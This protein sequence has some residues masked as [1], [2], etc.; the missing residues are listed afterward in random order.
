MSRR[1]S[2]VSGPEIAARML[3]RVPLDTATNGTIDALQSLCVE[4]KGAAKVLF[5]LERPRDFL[6]VLEAEGYNVQADRA[7]ISRVEEL[8][9]RNSVRVID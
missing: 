1:Y 8:C 5:D 4:R 2:G 3:I 7:F 9:G 6:V